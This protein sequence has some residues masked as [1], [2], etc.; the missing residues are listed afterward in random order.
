MRGLGMTY[1][2]YARDG[3]AVFD[4]DDADDKI[5]R[6]G[7]FCCVRRIFS[8]ITSSNRHYLHIGN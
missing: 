8:H 2:R 7:Y 3:I 6:V 4:D 5:K 1:L